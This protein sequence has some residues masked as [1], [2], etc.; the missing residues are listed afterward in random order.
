M[1]EKEKTFLLDEIVSIEPVG[2]IDT[3]DFTVPETHSFFANGILVHNSGGVEEKADQVVLLH[4]PHL[5][6]DEQ[7]KNKIEIHVAKNRFG[8]TGHSAFNFQPEFSLISDNPIIE[9]KHDTEV[10]WNE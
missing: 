5:Y 4:F 1:I 10:N 2:N 7:D 8:K 3:F 6:D 9:S